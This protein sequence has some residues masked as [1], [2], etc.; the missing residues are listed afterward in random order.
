MKIVHSALSEATP[1]ESPSKLHFEW[2]NLSNLIFIGP[3]HYGLLETDGQ[4][5]ALCGVLDKKEMDP[6][7]L[8]ESMFITCGK[9]KLEA[10]SG[11]LH[12]LH[13]NILKVGKFQEKL[14]DLQSNGWTN[15]VWDLG[16][17]YKNQHFWGLVTFLG[18]LA[19]LLYMTWNPI[20][21]TESKHWWDFIA[22][23]G[24]LR[25]LVLTTWDPRDHCNKD[26]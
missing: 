13:N 19:S 17:S 1:P 16:K 21:H 7:V 11:H 5:G 24:T 26:C 23:A 6:L 14:V 4:L 10:C 18:I 8:A 9:S 2:V 20:K 15:Q 12:K 22:S 25:S 3:Q